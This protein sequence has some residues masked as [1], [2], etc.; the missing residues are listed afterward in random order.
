LQIEE[1]DILKFKNNILIKLSIYSYYLNDQVS[2][3]HE[4]ENS[5]INLIIR[6]YLDNFTDY[7]VLKKNKV[8]IF[9]L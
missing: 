8:Q 1:N 2:L 6:S 9:S 7:K 5:P 4:I 3:S